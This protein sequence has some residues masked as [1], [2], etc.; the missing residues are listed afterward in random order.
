MD[1]VLQ[2]LVTKVSNRTG[3]SRPTSRVEGTTPAGK[4][5]GRAA[6]KVT[7]ARGRVRGRTVAGSRRRRPDR[8]IDDREEDGRP[9]KT[10]AKKAPAKKAPA[11]K[12]PAKKAPPK[13]VPAK[14]TEPPR[15]HRRRRQR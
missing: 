14:K 8:E 5:V 15:R 1:P 9:K 7:T 11:K 10:A 12:A 13:K 4:T 2:S 6:R 3:R